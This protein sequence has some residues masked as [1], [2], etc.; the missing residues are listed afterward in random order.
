MYPSTLQPVARD[1]SGR[2]STPTV[3]VVN[4]CPSDLGSWQEPDVRLISVGSGAEALRLAHTRSVD[5]WVVNTELPDL[6]GFELCEMLKSQHRQ[7][8]VCLMADAYSPQAE[9]A[10]FAARATMF[11]CKPQLA[12]WIETWLAHRRQQSA[13]G[14]RE[15]AI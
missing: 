7:R 6:S 2:R 12:A 11:G 15:V 5:L 13:V 8:T 10:A 9:R 1:E 4:A 3:V 14:S